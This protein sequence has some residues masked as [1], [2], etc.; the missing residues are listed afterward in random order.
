[1]KQISLFVI[2]FLGLESF[3]F[4]ISPARTAL[5]IK[6]LSHKTNHP[7]RYNQPRYI[8]QHLAEINEGEEEEKLLENEEDVN[9]A[10]KRQMLGFAIPA[11][12]I[13]LCNPLLSNIDNAFVGRMSGT[14]GLAALS[15]ATICTDQVLYLF[16]FLS[17]A[18]TGMVSRAYAS[19][20]NTENAR[21]AA[22]APLTLAIAI[23][24]I[25]SI[26]YAIFTPNLLSMLQVNPSLRPAASSYIHWRGSITWAAL[27][28]R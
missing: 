8:G 19:E 18:T 16:S 23:G 10:S 3:G 9:E 13:F 21:S 27:A 7:F 26:C 22:S 15:P 6:A 4:H 2:L 28:Q 14:S 12:G 1:M 25:I 5:R 20:K 11:L 24:S 17:R